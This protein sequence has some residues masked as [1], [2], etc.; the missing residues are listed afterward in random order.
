[1]TGL[2]CE[3]VKESSVSTKCKEFL[4]LAEGLLLAAEEAFCKI[5]TFSLSNFDHNSLSFD[6]VSSKSGILLVLYQKL[7]HHF[8][9]FSDI[10]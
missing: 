1:M 10:P 3:K 9:A 7:R 8:E 5:I 2:L 4:T 6:S